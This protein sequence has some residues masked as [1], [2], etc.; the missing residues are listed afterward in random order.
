L[1]EDILT[2][3]HGATTFGIKGAEKATEKIVLRVGRDRPHYH[4]LEVAVEALKLR[5]DEGERLGGGDERS[6]VFHRHL[7]HLTPHP[8]RVDPQKLRLLQSFSKPTNSEL[9]S[10]PIKGR[11]ASVGV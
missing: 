9:P 10:P 3:L 1:A 7:L 8:L 6:V 4:G 2:E 11:A 5:A